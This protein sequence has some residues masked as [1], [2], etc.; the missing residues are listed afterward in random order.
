MGP[1]AGTREGGRDPLNNH[2]SV[3]VLSFSMVVDSLVEY[4]SSLMCPQP[5]MCSVF[6]FV[7]LC[8][9]PHDNVYLVS[10]FYSYSNGPLD[11]K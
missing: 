3:S 6:L 9:F 2:H 7:M 11:L 5:D 1:V 10:T 4:D 8:I